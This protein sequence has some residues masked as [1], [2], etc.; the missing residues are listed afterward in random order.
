MSH[1]TYTHTY[2]C[3]RLNEFTT[4]DKAMAY[5][6]RMFFSPDLMAHWDESFELVHV[7]QC[8]AVCCSVLQC[9]AQE[10][11]EINNCAVCCERF[12]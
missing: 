2:H 5:E 12:D 11:F 3:V 10:W 1:D 6:M 9:V 7:L 8:V 4:F